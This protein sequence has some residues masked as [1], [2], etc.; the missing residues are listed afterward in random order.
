MS[1]DTE[2]PARRW[3]DVETAARVA[4]NQAMTPFQLTLNRI[5]SDVRQLRATAYGDQAIQQK[6]LVEVVRGMDDKLD[7][8]IEQR[9]QNTWLLRGVAAGLALNIAQITGLLPALLKLF[10]P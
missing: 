4:V 1:D 9:K 6:G 3:Q 8:I 2:H 10:A 7:Q 5:E